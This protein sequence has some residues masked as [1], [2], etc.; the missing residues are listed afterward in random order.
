LIAT[1]GAPSLKEPE[2]WSAIFK[3]FL[4]CCLEV[5]TSKRAT[6]RELLG[7]SGSS[8]ASKMTNTT[9]HPFLKLACPT[10]NLTPLVLKAKEVAAEMSSGSESY[11]ESV[12]DYY[13]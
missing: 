12:E 9:K 4:G 7:V 5:D 10:R 1:H 8:M 11:S 3:D 13:G 2:Q 6:S